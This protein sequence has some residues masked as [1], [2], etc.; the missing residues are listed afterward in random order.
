MGQLAVQLFKFALQGCYLLLEFVIF[1]N[2]NFRNL[3]IVAAVATYGSIVADTLSTKWATHCDG[4]AHLLLRHVEIES[5]RCGAAI[6]V[7]DFC[8]NCVR[9]GRHLGFWHID[10]VWLD[11]DL[12]AVG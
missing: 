2:Q 3:E 1:G 7:L 4:L 12:D 6:L 8:A 10:A 9:T 11:K 5:E